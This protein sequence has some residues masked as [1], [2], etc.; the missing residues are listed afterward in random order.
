ME[1][2]SGLVERL[3]LP[4]RYYLIVPED[5]RLNTVCSDIRY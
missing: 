5:I 2:V 3:I 1:D 4:D